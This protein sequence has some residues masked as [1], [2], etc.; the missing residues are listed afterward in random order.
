MSNFQLLDNGTLPAFA[1]PGGYPIIYYTKDGCCICPACAN[2]PCDDTVIGQTVF[3][4][5]DDMQ[6][7]DCG[8]PLESAYG[9]VEA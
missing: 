8:A 9:P 5:G 4:E 1:F 7:D 6:C 2:R 3:W